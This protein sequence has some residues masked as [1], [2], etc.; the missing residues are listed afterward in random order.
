MSGDNLSAISMYQACLMH[1]RAERVLK[2]IVAKH[3]KS[4]EI[5]R[6]EWI[7]VATLDSNKRA[8]GYTMSELS[9]VLDIKL[10]QLTILTSG[11]V[12]LGMAKQV[13]SPNDKR[14]KL[15]TITPKGKKL[16]DK[17]EKSMRQAL[18][19][20]LSD[21]PRDQ[22]TSYMQTLKLLGEAA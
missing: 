18:R 19:E 2:T 12:A 17:I 9:E 14:T 11:V 13:T 7:V 1:S 22:L 10:S 5:T 21:I 6:M 4:F 8:A 16:I 15:V 3:L 20:W